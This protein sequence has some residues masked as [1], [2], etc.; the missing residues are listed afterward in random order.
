MFKA[1]TRKVGGA[2]S[3]HTGGLQ[4]GFLEKTVLEQR[5]MGRGLELFMSSGEP[6][7]AYRGSDEHHPSKRR[8]GVTAGHSWTL[9]NFLTLTPSASHPASLPWS[10]SF[11][12]SWSSH[13]PPYRKCDLVASLKPLQCSHHKEGQRP[14]KGGS[15][16]SFPGCG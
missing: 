16:G 14:Q 13:L 9:N 2:W 15:M 7:E 12:P 3:I 1:L 6:V 4:A 10:S 5:V 11:P 8:A